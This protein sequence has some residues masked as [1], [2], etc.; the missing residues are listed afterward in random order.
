MADKFD[1]VH[2]YSFIINS[3]CQIIAGADAFEKKRN[4][5]E[6]VDS[7]AN[8]VKILYYYKDLLDTI[9]KDINDQKWSGLAE[10]LAKE[11]GKNPFPYEDADKITKVFSKNVL[12]IAKKVACF[13]ASRED[14]LSFSDAYFRA[15]HKEEVQQDA[16]QVSIELFNAVKRDE[17]H[18]E[19]CKGAFSKGYE[20]FYN[21]GNLDATINHVAFLSGI[22]VD[23][24]AVK[25]LQFLL[26][27]FIKGHARKALS[28]KNLL[29]EF[30]DE[31]S[32]AMEDGKTM[33]ELFTNFVSLAKG[34]E[35]F[36]WTEGANNEF[37]S[38]L[39]NNNRY[40]E[41]ADLDSPES[42]VFWRKWSQFLV[43]VILSSV[44]R[45]ADLEDQE[46]LKTI[47]PELDKIKSLKPTPFFKFSSLLVDQIKEEEEE[48][49]EEVVP[50][51]RKLAQRAID[52]GAL[53]QGGKKIFRY[54]SPLKWTENLEKITKGP[55]HSL[56]FREKELVTKTNNKGIGEFELN[57]NSINSIILYGRWLMCNVPVFKAEGSSLTAKDLENVYQKIIG[58]LKTLKDEATNKQ[59]GTDIK[60]HINALLKEEVVKI[61]SDDES[62][63]KKLRLYDALCVPLIDETKNPATVLKLSLF[64]MKLGGLA[65]D[66]LGEPGRKFTRDEEYFLGNEELGQVL[67]DLFA[68][69]MGE[70]FESK[71][72]FEEKTDGSFYFS[73]DLM[74]NAASKLASTHIEESDLD[75]ACD[76]G[77]D[78]DFDLHD[79]ITNGNENTSDEK[80]SDK[81]EPFIGW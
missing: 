70:E 1:I 73:K 37:L 32:S 2:R 49:E 16:A 38:L 48:E 45:F 17:K 41:Y 57:N 20:Q 13:L 67:A 55:F 47:F 63:T 14:P 72:F 68:Q 43:E 34:V 25:P 51:A 35:D 4:W 8:L 7:A 60:G 79:I 59:K 76:W 58:T 66:I 39:A 64:P 6:N 61:R 26:Y 22:L 21:R 27:A 71:R 69:A 12:Q 9:L 11:K 29:E 46:K 74:N 56:F 75:E 81:K 62:I 50:E 3:A 53:Y 40:K 80:K 77:E 33:R 78:D 5:E 18:F 42:A 30:L 28:G 44:G 23:V 52:S 10:R 36:L 31:Q 15:I 54:I 24:K 65:E 19:L